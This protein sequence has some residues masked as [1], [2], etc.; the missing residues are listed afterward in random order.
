[1]IYLPSQVEQIAQVIAERVGDVLGASVCIVDTNRRVIACHGA[2]S[3]PVD[4][5]WQPTPYARVPL[6]LDHLVGEVI[7]AAP[8]TGET[9]SPR[10]MQVLIELIIGQAMALI[11]SGA[12]APHHHKNAF[13]HDLLH[14]LIADEAAIQREA[15][16]LGLDLS[17]P[18]AVILIDAA[19][20]ILRNEAQA[21]AADTQIRRRAQMVIGSV[22]GFFH[23]PNDTICAYIGA[24]EVA[25]LKASNTQN[26]ILWAEPGAAVEPVSGSWANL[27]ALK[28][29]SN[30]LLHNL[31][32]ELDAAISIGIGRYHPG[33]RGLALSYQDA[34]V[35]L[36]LGRRFHGQ[37]GVHC[38][39]QLGIAAFVGV[40]DE[41]TKI[42]L[43]TYLL[44]PLDHE[45]ELI[46][47]LRVF[48]ATNCCPS[49]T[50]RQLAI[51][52]NTVS[53]RLEKIALLTGLDPRRFDDAV[54]IRLALLLRELQHATPAPARA[55]A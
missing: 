26:L 55:A 41:R 52:R 1:M 19:D 46:E 51:H 23:L 42:D 32:R 15:R 50:A 14:G 5:D 37:N 17:T 54:Q 35:A 43:A 4:G 40:A 24:G 22:V 10:L 45:P 2:P 47:T 27:A 39:D 30:Q 25:V 31:R 13:I 11:R 7:I 34:R 18:R 21:D 33:L 16:L 53:Y 28:R 3:A 36:S 44:S 49:S 9:I 20:Y 6:R 38:L 29:A 8:A 12:A 48:L